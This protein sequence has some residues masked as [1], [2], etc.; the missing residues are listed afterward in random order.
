MYVLRDYARNEVSCVKQ[1]V[2]YTI[3]IDVLYRLAVVVA[4]RHVQHPAAR[5]RARPAA[6]LEESPMAT[7][8]RGCRPKVVADLQQRHRIRLFSR[9]A[10][11]RRRPPRN[12]VRKSV[13][14]QQRQRRRRSACWSR[15]PA[16]ALLACIASRPSAHAGIERRV[17]AVDG[18]VVALIGAI[19]WS[20]CRSTARRRK[21]SAEHAADQVFR[22]LAD[23]TRDER[24]RRQCNWLFAVFF[25][26]F[27]F[28][29]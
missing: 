6:S 10:N 16:A 12:S 18:K 14:F 27:F 26:F 5:R 4:V 24:Q 23:E 8:C 13:F 7:T 19:A 17:I 3:G 29:L 2:N 28:F 15:R 22:T 9:A 25:F 20:K 1:R 21:S 11:R